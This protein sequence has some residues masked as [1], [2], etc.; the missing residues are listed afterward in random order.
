V[1]KI[2]IL[3][4][5]VQHNNNVVSY[6]LQVTYVKFQDKLWLCPMCS[7]LCFRIRQCK[8][9]IDN[10]RQDTEMTPTQNRDGKKFF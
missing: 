8:G 1:Y 7:R 5:C 4:T 6:V 2:L 9:N 3:R 10:Q